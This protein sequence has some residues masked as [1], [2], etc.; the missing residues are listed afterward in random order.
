M[1]K[2]KFEAVLFDIDGTLLD[3]SRFIF[4]AYKHA[5]KHHLRKD[6]TWKEVAKTLGLHLEECYCI[7]TELDDVKDLMSTHNKFQ[8]SNFQLIKAYKNT[9][10][11]LKVL[12]KAK[13]K[14]GVV[15]NR[16]GDQVFQSLKITGVDQ[17]FDVIVTPQDVKNPKPHAEPVL[18]ALKK[19]KAPAE[20]TAFFGDCQSDIQAGKAAG[21]VTI[22]ASYGF[23]GEK[24]LKS[25]PDF[26]VS[27][28]SEILPIILR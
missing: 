10:S 3:T 23:H 19:L 21:C 28:I 1:K 24:L 22:G 5:I 4:Q 9:I 13:I 8:Y 12:K 17:Y 11:T 18:K 15:T 6:V 2:R 14:M 25:K 20:K 7:L 27:D 16:F 26:L